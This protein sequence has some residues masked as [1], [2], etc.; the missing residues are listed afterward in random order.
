STFKLISRIDPSPEAIYSDS[1]PSSPLT[2]CN[3]TYSTIYQSIELITKAKLYHFLVNSMRSSS[4]SLRP[5]RKAKWIRFVCSIRGSQFKRPEP[6]GT[7]DLTGKPIVR[8]IPG[9]PPLVKV[10]ALVFGGPI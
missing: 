8:E 3:L 10:W 7:V 2:R 9:L 1:R 4:N 6:R 5:L